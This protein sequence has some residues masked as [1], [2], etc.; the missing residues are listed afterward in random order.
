[1]KPMLMFY[2]SISKSSNATVAIRRIQSS[3]LAKARKVRWRFGGVS[4]IVE[5][6]ENGTL[7]IP[8]LELTRSKKVLYLSSFD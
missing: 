5:R 4:G 8:D 3:K 7:S 1:M 2:I 6:D